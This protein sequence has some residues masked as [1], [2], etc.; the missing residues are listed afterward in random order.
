MTR[1]LGWGTTLVKFNTLSH[2]T[3]TEIYDICY[4]R[5]RKTVS[6][7]WLSQIH[8]PLAL[9]VWYMDDGSLGKGA[10]M[11]IS[12]YGFA[13]KQHIILQNWLKQKWGVDSQI[14]KDTRGRGYYLAFPARSRDSFL[15]LIRDYVIPS[16]QYKTLPKLSEMPCTICGKSIQPKRAV[17]TSGRN[18]VCNSKK[19]KSMLAK[20]NRGWKPKKPRPCE[21]CGAIFTLIQEKEK[22]C[23]PECKRL[24]RLQQK[25]ARRI[26][27]KRPLL[28]KACIQCTTTFTPTRGNQKAC[29]QECRR[30]LRRQSIDRYERK[31]AEKTMSMTWKSLTTTISSPMAF[32]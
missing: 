10:N 21:I 18:V 4:P 20:L 12:T 6:S 14:R 5:G 19:C 1:N 22:G 16:M 17:V 3:F 13:M 27:N 24:H 25:R 11:R 28:P 8:S 15:D 32:W 26:R 29:S 7:N 9:A 23:S 30:Q 31:T 2:P